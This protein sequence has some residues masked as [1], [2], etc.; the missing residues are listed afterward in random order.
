MKEIWEEVPGFE[1][2]YKV[3]NLGQVKTFNFMNTGKERVL[4]LTP[5]R[6][7][8]LKVNLYGKD[9]HINMQVHRLVAQAFIPNQENKPQV[10]HKDGN[11]QNNK[12]NN[13]E[14][15]TNQENIIHAHKNGLTNPASNKTM[16]GKFGELNPRSK[17]VR[18]VTTGEVFGSIRE[19]GRE[20]KLNYR[21]ISAC[22][23]GKLKTSGKHPKTKER[24]VWI[25]E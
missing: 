22:C 10:N 20:Y 2:K 9:K 3:S 7:G 17:K 21:H 23:K 19:A 12:I 14:W 8:Y 6:K 25:Y 18:C 24:L 11:K 5:D 1:G 4:K 15:V 16:L 13:L